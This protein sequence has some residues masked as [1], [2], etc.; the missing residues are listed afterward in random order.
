MFQG[1]IHDI[2]GILVIGGIPEV[3]WLKL[4]EFEFVFH[5]PDDH[6]HNISLALKALFF[7][8]LHDCG[9]G[10]FLLQKYDTGE[11]NH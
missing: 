4:V 9:I 6:L 10:Q 5:A 1:K 8:L 3:G 7:E 11:E 2:S